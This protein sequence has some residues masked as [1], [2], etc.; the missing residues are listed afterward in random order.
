[1]SPQTSIQAVLDHHDEEVDDHVGRHADVLKEE[2]EGANLGTARHGARSPAREEERCDESS[3]R[4]RPPAAHHDHAFGHRHVFTVLQ[5]EGHGDESVNDDVEDGDMRADRGHIADAKSQHAP[6]GFH[7]EVGGES[8]DNEGNEGVGEEEVEHQ[9][10]GGAQLDT[11]APALLHQEGESDGAVHQH[12][13]E[14]GGLA[15]DG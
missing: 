7:G 6:L 10:A 2:S 8:E 12:G 4:N 3:H 14:G 11:A 13:E 15:N 1:V 5:G 9:E